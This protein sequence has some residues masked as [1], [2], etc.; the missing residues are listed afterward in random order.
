M[1]AVFW[2]GAGR[3]AQPGPLTEEAGEGP[4]LWAHWATK[5]PPRALVK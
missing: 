1:H 2:G 5:G 4:G 3:Y